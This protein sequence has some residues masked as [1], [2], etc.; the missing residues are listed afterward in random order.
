MDCV[1]S[2]PYATT[3]VVSWNNFKS[4]LHDLYLHGKTKQKNVDT[5]SSS[6]IL[7]SNPSV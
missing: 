4:S 7:V 6:K 2:K 5:K 3:F 1:N